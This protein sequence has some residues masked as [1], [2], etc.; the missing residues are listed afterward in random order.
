MTER[1]R[2][3][4]LMATP[5]DM[6]LA[7]GKKY[8]FSPLTIQDLEELSRFARYR[9]LREAEKETAGM[10]DDIRRIVCDKAATRC[11]QMTT[12]ELRGE[13]L[14]L[15]CVRYMFWLG[16]KK[17]HPALTYEVLGILMTPEIIA[18]EM[19]SAKKAAGD[20][21]PTLS[22]Q[23]GTDQPDQP[24]IQKTLNGGEIA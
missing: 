1:D 16:L 24:I 9:M 19:P 5:I 8:R 17:N 20:S 10:S 22:P 21:D 12:N 18:R 4:A 15:P 2:I 3:A 14:Q 23:Q 6:D 11:M 7:D 13:L